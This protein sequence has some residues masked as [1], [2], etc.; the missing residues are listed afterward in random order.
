MELTRRDMLKMSLLGGAALLLPL[1]RQA[2]TELLVKNRLPESRLPQRFVAPFVTPPVARPVHRSDTTDFYEM[3]MKQ[4]YP[5]IIP[6]LKTEIWGYEGITPGPTIEVQRGR[7]VVVRHKNEIWNNLHEHTSV[8]LHGNAS[9]PQYDG[10]ANDVTVPGEFKDY[11]YPNFQNARTLWYHD[12]G[13]HATA[14]NAYMGCAAFYI[15]HDERERK[16]GDPA[17]TTYKDAGTAIPKG[18]YDVPLVLRDGIFATDGSL[19]FD[20]EGNS[21][22]FGD[23][24]LVNGSPWPL[25]KVERRKYRFRILNASISR[26]FDLALSTGEPLTVIG[27]DGG[28]GIEP[29]EVRNMRIGMAERYEV[30][31]DFSGYAPGT[32]VDLN[33]RGLPNIVD[34]ASTGKVMRFEVMDT[35]VDNTP[36]PAKLNPDNELMNLQASQA[37]KTRYFEFGRSCVGGTDDANGVCVGGT[38]MWTINDKVWDKNRVDANPGLNDVEIWE[39]ENKS[40]GWFHPVHMHLIDFKILSRNG[41]APHPWERGPKDV[42]YIGEGETVRVL[43]KF[44]PQ[45]GKYMMHC[46][47]LVHEDHDMMT[48]FEV[49]SGGDDPI[50]AAP[51]KPISQAGPLW[52]ETP[53]PPP[54]QTTPEQ[55][56]PEHTKPEPPNT[57]PTITILRPGPGSKTRDRTPKIVARVEDAQTKLAKG[58]VKLFVDGR[59]VRSFSFNRTTGQLAYTSRALRPGRHSVKIVATDV[60]KRI[61]TRSWTFRVVK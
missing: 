56:T 55:T 2:R 32:K 30:V 50:T 3:S 44:G 34:F 29:V 24:I 25:M 42:A 23:V 46:H 27:H 8:H 14:F 20:D 45:K 6:G 43:M 48:Q 31:I 40:G 60:K 51:A 39:L 22:L 11:H 7:N 38:D 37:T 59:R 49:G 33:N 5:E 9:L 57:A 16:L 21:S 17:D 36:L 19:I 54:E 52:E 18:A 47:N 15:T 1:E 12:H 10:Y 41:R 26:G 28:L 35:P 4:A 58:N 61:S 53:K 13:V